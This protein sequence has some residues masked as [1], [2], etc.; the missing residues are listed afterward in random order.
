MQIYNT[1]ILQTSVG[2]K[3]FYSPAALSVNHKNKHPLSYTEETN[4]IF[5]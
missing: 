4:G 2:H 5:E 3:P 1:D